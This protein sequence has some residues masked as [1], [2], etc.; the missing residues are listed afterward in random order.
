[1][2][3]FMVEARPTDPA[4]RGAWRRHMSRKTIHKTPRSIDAVYAVFDKE[5]GEFKAGPN[6][7]SDSEA[8]AALSK[9]GDAERVVS[10]AAARG[11]QRRKLEVVRLAGRVGELA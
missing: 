11:G 3:S 5:T 1:M 9:L 7:W 8:K 10:L 4:G 2:L 6:S